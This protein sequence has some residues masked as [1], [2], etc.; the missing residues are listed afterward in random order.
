M[1]SEPQNG[2]HVGSHIKSTY[3]VHSTTQTFDH[4][5]RKHKF[6]L[7]S[8]SSALFGTEF[9]YITLKKC[10]RDTS[11][12]QS[13]GPVCVSGNKAQ[14]LLATATSLQQ[15]R[16]MEGVRREMAVWWKEWVACLCVL[17]VC[18]GVGRRWERGE[19]GPTVA[20]RCSLC[21]SPSFSP[22]FPST[23]W[24]QSFGGGWQA[25]SDVMPAVQRWQLNLFS[26][27]PQN[28]Y[29]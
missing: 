15:G 4:Q 2:C 14:R 7:S 9:A 10:G 17:R 12:V 26:E 27:I 8:V 23:V 28:F 19:R 21:L 22:S 3:C 16:W 24:E 13:P 29:L 25:I 18:V 11:P 1:N 6:H 5:K 20:H